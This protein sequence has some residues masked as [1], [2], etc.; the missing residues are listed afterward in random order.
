M[1]I[2]A[3]GAAQLRVLVLAPSGAD[4]A[5]AT[6]ILADAGIVAC[7]C[8]SLADLCERLDDGAGAL[9]LTEEALFGDQPELL[10]TQLGAQPAWSDVP[11]IVLTTSSDDAQWSEVLGSLFAASGNL[12]LI[13]RPCRAATLASAVQVALRARR[14]QYEVRELLEREQRARREA[15]QALEQARQSEAAREALL[16]SERA[17]RADAE[18]ANRLKDEFLATLSHELRT[19][20]AV[21]LSWSRVLQVKFGDGGEQLRRGLAIISDNAGAQAQIISDL[22][23]MS[24]I[25]SGKVGLE[26]Q[27]MDLATLVAQA[28]ASHVPAAEAKGIAI[29]LDQ[30]LAGDQVIADSTRL[31]QVFWNLLSNAIKFTPAGG[32]VTVRTSAVGARLQVSVHD[33]G[34]GIARDFL[35]H[36]FDRFR[37]ADGSAAR[38]HGGLGLGLAIVKQLVELHG[39]TIE[40]RSDG[41]GRGSCFVVSLPVHRHHAGTGVAQRERSAGIEGTLGDQA[42]E[43]LTVLVVEDQVHML[44]IVARV[45]EEHG[46]EVVSACSGQEALATLHARGAHAFDIVVSDIGLPGMDGYALLR[47]IRLDLGIPAEQLPAVAVTAFARTEDRARALGGGFQAHLTK[48]YQ[49]AQLVAWVRALAGPGHARVVAPDGADAA[50]GASVPRQVAAT[51]R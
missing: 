41:A 13:E 44:E 30:A 11:L 35:P 21:I 47:A 42:L 9:L 31:Q 45:L 28:V 22:L 18:R 20:L 7:G 3:P 33:T 49:L 39:G 38:R 6:R 29:E 12:T 32:R 43:G 2:E 17:A 5:V 48:P 40:A 24:R 19:P 8:S 16:E 46:A 36:L 23:D 50:L 1:T 34:E 37:Q 27:P 4:A 15:S 51:P 14:K 25:M 26:T 10:A